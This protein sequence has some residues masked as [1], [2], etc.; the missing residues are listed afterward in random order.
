MVGW[1]FVR[2]LDVHRVKS[3]FFRHHRH[4]PSA[5]DRGLLTRPGLVLIGGDCLG[6]RVEGERKTEPPEK[7]L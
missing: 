6:C 5:V 3:F 4:P 2:T 1:P 7:K